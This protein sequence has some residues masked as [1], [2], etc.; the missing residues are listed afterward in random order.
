MAGRLDHLSECERV[1]LNALERLAILVGV[2]LRIGCDVV[3][4]QASPYQAISPPER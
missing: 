3:C 4:A 2:T 1:V